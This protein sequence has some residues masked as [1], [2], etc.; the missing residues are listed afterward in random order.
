MGGWGHLPGR[1]RHRNHH[2]SRPGGGRLR[3]QMHLPKGAGF[4]KETVRPVDPGFA[5]A[6]AGGGRAEGAGPEQPGDRWWHS[7]RD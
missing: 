5:E 7:K 2:Q 3:L 1:W 4:V 6:K